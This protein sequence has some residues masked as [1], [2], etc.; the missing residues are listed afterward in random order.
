MKTL[1]KQIV[2]LLV[3]MV[4]FSG[5][6]QKNEMKAV[7][8][9]MAKKDFAEA[10]TNL[11]LVENM[12]SNLD[13]K[14]KAKF[15]YLKAQALKGSGKNLDA[16]NVINELLAFEKSTGKSKYSNEMSKTL[17]GMVSNISS[18]AWKDYEAKNWKGATTKFAKVQE[19]SPKDTIYLYYSALT[20]LYD[21]DYDLSLSNYEK[22]IKMGFTGIKTEYSALNIASNKREVFDS[23]KQLD[24]FIRLKLHKDPVTKV[25]PSKVGDIYKNVASIYVNKEEFD[26][27][28]SSIDNAR[29][30]FPDD[31]NLILVAA[32][33][34]YKM[35]DNSKYIEYMNQAKEFTPDNPLIY[36]NIGVISKKEGKLDEARKAFNKALEINPD[37]KD[38]LLSLADLELSGQDALVEAMNKN[39][40]NFDKYDE[41]N[42]QLKTLFRKVLPLYEKASTIQAEGDTKDNDVAILKT[43]MSIY[44]QLEMDDKAKEMRDKISQM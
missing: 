30:Q 36:N 5:F 28:L 4:A 35:G 31:V 39:M 10:L 14:T 33:V 41:L 11:D 20:A 17:T 15:Y 16:A 12:L 43:L 25:L 3:F 8:K 44:S 19:L 24:D 29:K 42:A 2:L 6:A 26:K 27:A 22:L 32:D 13:D 23:K 18:S 38:A 1:K 21:K 37:Y 40:S 34:A 7:A 9:A